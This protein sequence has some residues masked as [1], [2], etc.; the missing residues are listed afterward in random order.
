MAQ[1]DRI[2]PSRRD[3]R[4]LAI[5]TWG[6]ALGA[7]IEL[8]L[9]ASANRVLTVSTRWQA[10]LAIGAAVVVV[11]GLALLLGDRLH[12]P[13]VLPEAGRV[14]GRVVRRRGIALL[15]AFGLLLFYPLLVFGPAGRFAA[16]LF[17]RL[18]LFWLVGLAIAFLLR[19]FFPGAAWLHRLLG[20]MVGYALFLRALSFVPTV[21]AYPFSL[22]WS[23]AS[24]YYYASLFRSA[25]IYGRALPLPELHPTRYFLQSLP[26]LIPAS[27]LWLHRLWQTVLWWLLPVATAALLVARQRVAGRWLRLLVAGWIVL[28]LLQ[29][30]VYYHLLVPV[31]I[32]LIGVDRNHPWRSTIFVLAASAW[33][34][35]SRI[36]W[37]PVPAL[38]AGSLVVLEAPPQES[39][40]RVFRWPVAWVVLGMMTALAAQAAY[41]RLTGISVDHFT[42][43]LTSDLLWY[44]LLPSATYPLGLLPAVVLASAPMALSLWW[45]RSAWGPNLGLARGAALAAG[46]LALGLGGLVVS[47]KIG[48]GSNLHNLDAYLVLLLLVGCSLLLRSQGAVPTRSTSLPSPRALALLV[49]VPVGFALAAGGPWVAPNRGA[50]ASSLGVIRQQVQQAQVTGKPVLFISQRQLL[51]FGEIP[52]VP[53]VPDYETVFLMEMAMSGDRPYLDRF[54]ELL[55]QQAFGLIVVDHLTT[56]Y[57]GKDHSFGEEN[58]AWV[59]EVSRP[60]LCWYEPVAE[61]EE[62]HVDLLAARAPGTTCEG[63]GS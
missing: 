46:L 21:S 42:S 29:G 3:G 61:L 14:A 52:G 50:A 6:L 41:V 57:Q 40:R 12:V 43:R 55:E 18:L 59:R 28:Y 23:E 24:R 37:F 17:P 44:R 32:V 48:G 15:L 5:L 8:T 56:A 54:H 34:G 49:A 35:V 27:P 38:L 62:P 7:L 30:P 39:D 16:G 10:A 20:T 2:D 13:A 9:Q 51:T 11:A 25:A 22:G 53:L 26:F 36:N 19:P 33:A 58:D 1:P 31:V 47:L 45:S 4:R 60:I 63:N